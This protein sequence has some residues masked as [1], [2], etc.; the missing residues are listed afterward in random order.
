MPATLT[1]TSQVILPNLTEGDRQ[2]VHWARVNA[3]LAA[4]D[5]REALLGEIRH[6][7]TVDALTAAAW[8]VADR[9]EAA[10]WEAERRQ[11]QG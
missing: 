9:A 11:L 8:I 2:M 5:E 7:R 4:V 3:V 10:A 6:V 1:I